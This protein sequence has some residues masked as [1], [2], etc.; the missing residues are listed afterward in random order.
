MGPD[1]KYFALI[2]YK[3]SFKIMD[4]REF[5]FDSFKYSPM[6]AKDFVLAAFHLISLVKSFKMQ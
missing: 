2:L 3:I 1:T 5:C 4:K 6:T